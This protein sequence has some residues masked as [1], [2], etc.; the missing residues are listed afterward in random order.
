MNNYNNQ[1]SSYKNEHQLE[2][3]LLDNLDKDLPIFEGCASFGVSLGTRDKLGDTGKQEV[4]QLN[5]DRFCHTAIVGKSGSGKSNLI[6]QMELQDIKSGAGVAIIATHQEDALYPLSFIPPERI[7]DVVIIDA[8]DDTY[9]PCI[10]PLAVDLDNKQEVNRA[11]EKTVDLFTSHIP[12]SY[13]GP[14]FK[15]M[16]RNGL[17]LIMNKGNKPIPYI[18]QLKD[19]FTEPDIVKKHLKYCDDKNVFNYWVK[20]FAPAQRSNDEPA[21]TSWFLSKVDYFVSNRTLAALF[22]AHKKTIDF[23]DIVR[24]NKILIVLAPENYI[25]HD[26]AMFIKTMVISELKEAIITRVDNENGNGVIRN[27]HKS[28][29]NN[30]QI[31]PF[32]IYIDEFGEVANDEF[33]K[34]FSQIRKFNAGIIVGFQN[35]D[36]LIAVEDNTDNNRSTTRLLQSVLGNTGTIIAFNTSHKDT[37]TF[38]N[39]FGIKDYEMPTINKYEARAVIQNNGEKIGPFV[40]QI[41]LKPKVI[42]SP[43][44]SEI[45]KSLIDK[46]G[47]VKIEK[48]IKET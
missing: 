5:S 13:A 22:G 31:D 45:Y 39:N 24:N 26:A 8:T 40:L 16:A 25:G 15:N 18:G 34:I 43:L 1:K 35:F 30:R 14:R 2:N 41:P 23:K 11:I 36:Q 10:N 32:Y 6:H 46:G 7:D 17:R 3:K 48:L 9:L 19:A 28:N 12:S 44:P 33:C 27:S 37:N 29:F 20:E 47:I 42:N 21:V 38:A 4:I